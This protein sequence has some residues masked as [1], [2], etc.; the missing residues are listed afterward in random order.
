MVIQGG[1][2]GVEVRFSFVPNGLGVCSAAMQYKDTDKGWEDA[3]KF[4]EEM[5]EERAVE[6]ARGMM[7]KIAAAT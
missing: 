6:F 3:D 1:D 5:T 2:E 4:F 7:Q